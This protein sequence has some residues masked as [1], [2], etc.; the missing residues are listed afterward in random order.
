MYVVID[1]SDRSVKVYMLPSTPQDRLSFI[2]S[3]HKHITCDQAFYSWVSNNWA[4]HDRVFAAES[5]PPYIYN[6]AY[7]LQ[8][9]RSTKPL[10]A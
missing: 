7:I 6:Q 9:S 5:W 3:P 2:T 1:S 8:S 4:S 10:T